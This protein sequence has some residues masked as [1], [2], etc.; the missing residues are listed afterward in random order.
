MAYATL[1]DIER[2]MDPVDLVQLTDDGRTG[3]IDTDVVDRALADADEEVD[4]YLGGRYPVPL[5]PVPGIIRKTSVDIAIW[6][7][8]SRRR[9]EVPEARKTRYE[10]A[11]RFLGKVAEGKI[12]LGSEDPDGNPPSASG[13]G[14]TGEDQVFTPSKLGRF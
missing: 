4:G 2:Q 3:E 12:S 6:N 1:T 8:W 13:I 14:S 5:D 10:N 9:A 11:I 7:L